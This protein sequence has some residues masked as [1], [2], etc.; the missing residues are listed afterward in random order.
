[1][2]LSEQLS[3]GERKRGDHFFKIQLL[4]GIIL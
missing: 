3:N 1:M 4:K 2:G